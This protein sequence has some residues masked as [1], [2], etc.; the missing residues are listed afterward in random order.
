MK[1]N[2]I[3]VIAAVVLVAIA[4]TVVVKFHI[5]RRVYLADSYARLG[6]LSQTHEHF[7]KYGS[8]L[9][10]LHTEMMLLGAC[11]DSE[12][13][14]SHP[15]APWWPRP[16]RAPY[17]RVPFK[18]RHNRTEELS[19]VI[20]KRLEFAEQIGVTNWQQEAELYSR[21]VQQ[22]NEANKTNGE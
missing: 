6:A 9:A 7:F 3:L 22:I 11:R 21:Y 10:R 19:R 18:I 15:L 2:K 8:E 20:S 4:V 12:E 1:R 17:K 14:L 16:P 13:I 5:D